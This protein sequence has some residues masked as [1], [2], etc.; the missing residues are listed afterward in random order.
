MH[1]MSSISLPKWA[2]RWRVCIQCHRDLEHEPTSFACPKCDGWHYCSMACYDKDGPRHRG[3]ECKSHQI[4]RAFDAELSLNPHAR[5]L[6]Q[7]WLSHLR[8]AAPLYGAA[9]PV[10][11]ISEWIHDWM[12][13]CAPPHFLVPHDIQLG[14]IR[15][16]SESIRVDYGGTEELWIKVVFVPA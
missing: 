15:K 3:L 5:T 12:V 2:T 7:S 10:D 8:V 4:M 13:R 11:P 9:E 6:L 16:W 14:N 1:E